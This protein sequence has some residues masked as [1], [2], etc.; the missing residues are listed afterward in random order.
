MKNA[1]TTKGAFLALAFL[2]LCLVPGLNTPARAKVFNP[3]TFTLANG[4]RVVSHA[5][6]TVESVSVGI[7]VAA[8]ARNEEQTPIQWAL[9]N[10]ATT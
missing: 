7:W 5:M 4:M 8:G 6:D 10:L 1:S 9:S 2:A 3:E